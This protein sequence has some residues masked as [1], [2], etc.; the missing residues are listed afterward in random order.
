LEN[1]EVKPAWG[2]SPNWKEGKGSSNQLFLR[3]ISPHGVNKK[4]RDVEGWG[5]TTPKLVRLSLRG[6]SITRGEQREEMG[7]LLNA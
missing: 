6:D 7:D 4:N 1:G 5:K 2:R 3:R